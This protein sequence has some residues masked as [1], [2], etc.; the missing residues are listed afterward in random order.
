MN[1]QTGCGKTY[2]GKDIFGKRRNFYCIGG[3]FLCPECK[4]K[5]E[6]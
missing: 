2:I 3:E 6:K 4:K 5:E 1:K